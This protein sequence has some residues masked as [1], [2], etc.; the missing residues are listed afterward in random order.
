MTDEGRNSVS[1]VDRMQGVV[2]HLLPHR[3]LTAVMYYSTRLGFRPWKNWQIRWFIQRYGVDIS[4]APSADPNYYAHFNA[5]FTRT[6]RAGSRPLDGD[7][8]AIVCPADGTLSAIGDIHAGKLLQAKGQHYSL[9]TLLGADNGRA[10]PFDG[11]RF[12][13]LYLSPRD[14]HRVH[15]PVA[16]RLR[17]MTYIPGHLFS[18]NFATARAVPRLFT[19]NE[20]LVCL[21]D[22]E[23]GPMALILVGAMLVAGMETVWSGPVTPPRGQKMRSWRYDGESA[24]RLARG[25]EMGRFNAGSTVILLFPNR[26]IDWLDGFESGTAV[27]MGQGLARS[28]AQG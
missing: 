18:V 23:L 25:E 22:T 10:A 9:H 24:I 20:R 17:E 5:F 26:R 15:M 3:L 27:R 28:T 11:G 6:L 21:F 7:P 13:T 4:E 8:E 14:Y 16:G 1:G 19:R 2:Q 12:A